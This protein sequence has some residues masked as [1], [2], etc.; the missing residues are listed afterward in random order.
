MYNIRSIL[1]QKALQAETSY[2]LNILFSTE[3][4]NKSQYDSLD[5]DLDELIRMTTAT[6]KKLKTDLKK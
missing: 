1:G 4:L 5:S 3:F 6:V 2:W